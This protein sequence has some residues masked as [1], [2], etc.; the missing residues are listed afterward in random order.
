MHD[1]QN[2]THAAAPRKPGRRKGSAGVGVRFQIDTKI[3][4][5]RYEK[6]LE[7]NNAIALSEGK[8]ALTWP[9]II[10]RAMD[11]YVSSHPAALRAIYSAHAV[12]AAETNAI[13]D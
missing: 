10:S 2:D 9:D 6:W 4:R 11:F 3:P 5:R 1:S 13:H 12:R 8:A 7:A